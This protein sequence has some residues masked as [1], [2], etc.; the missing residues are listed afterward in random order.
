LESARLRGSYKAIA[1]MLCGLTWLLVPE[2]VSKPLLELSYVVVLH[3]DSFQLQYQTLPFFFL[4]EAGFSI[5]LDV[6]GVIGCKST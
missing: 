5:L 6:S 4:L 3:A 1:E 2:G